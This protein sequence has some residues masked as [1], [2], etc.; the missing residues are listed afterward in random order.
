MLEKEIIN[1]R[2]SF[3]NQKQ[4]YR[5]ISDFHVACARRKMRESHLY[6]SRVIFLI[7]CGLIA[8]SQQISVMY[9]YAMKW[10]KE[11]PAKQ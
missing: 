5:G 6:F 11:T 8:I 2:G 1:Y 3:F 4:N 7:H 10:M 9:Y